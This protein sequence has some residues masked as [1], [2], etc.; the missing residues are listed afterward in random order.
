[1]KEIRRKKL[2]SEI[3]REISNLIIKQRNKDDRIGLVSVTGVKLTPDFSTLTVF[4]S[5]FGDEE[6]NN[7]TWRALLQ[8]AARFQSETSRNLRLRHTPRIVFKLD[9]SI[10][11]GDRLL[12]LMEDDPG[13]A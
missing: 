4:V 1:M 8:H 3:Q 11:E 6:E 2:E 10:K 7:E 12:G 5:P 13:N 9:T